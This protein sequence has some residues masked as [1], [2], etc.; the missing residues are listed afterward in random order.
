MLNVDDII[1]TANHFRCIDLIID[2]AKATLT[3][4]FIKNIH[5]IL[6]NGTSDSRKD[7]FSMGNYKKFR[8]CSEPP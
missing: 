6:K 1:E 8:N 5:L 2:N 7:W 4:K 3:E